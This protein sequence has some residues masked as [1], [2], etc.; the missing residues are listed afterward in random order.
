MG[1]VAHVLLATERA[2][3]RHQLDRDAILVEGEHARDV[4]AVVP[5]ALATGVDVE[6]PIAAG[7]GGH[8]QGRLGL[9][10]R[11]LDALGLE[12]LVHR[13]RTRRE[14]LT[15]VGSPRVGAGREHI[16]VG[17]PDRQ[18]RIVGERGH[19]VGVRRVDVVGDLDEFDRGTG[20]L[21]GVGHHDGQHVAR[22][23]RGAA[24]RNHHRPVLVDDAHPQFAG[25]VGSGEHG[26]HARRGE[27]GGGVDRH[28][29]GPGMR[30]EVERGV[31]QARDAD[32]VDVVALAEGQW[33]RFVLR[34][35][36][37][38][39]GSELRIE[40]RAVCDRIDGVEDLHVAGA[41]AEVGT[42]VRCHPLLGERITLLV[43]LRLRSHH[44]ARDAEPTLQAAACRER[45]GEALALGLVDAFERGHRRAGDLRQVALTRH[46]RLAIDEHRATTALARRR[47]AVLRRGDVEFF[48]QRC[49]QVGMIP[50]HGHRRS[51][52]LEGHRLGDL[53]G[54]W[55]GRRCIE[56]L[57]HA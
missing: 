41:A 39:S 24:D 54:Q 44:D 7:T 45:V 8:G 36:S 14:C 32:V 49:E 17:P 31:Q 9:E 48:P 52:D 6:A 40:R 3:V 47:A 21:A 50:A 10:E 37:A 42:E 27:R 53:V 20:M 5:H 30:G 35:G 34:A 22:V 55:F 43:D 12:P 26:A 16:R 38:D 19:G 15:E 2:A 4:V 18:R 51:V 28:D 25:E 1:L 13:E 33:C 11:M 46:D 57:G 23:R 29:A 56:D